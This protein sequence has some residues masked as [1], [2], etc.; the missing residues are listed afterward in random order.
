MRSVM[1]LL[2]SLFLIVIYFNLSGDYPPQSRV[3]RPTQSYSSTAANSAKPESSPSFS[4]TAQENQ[5]NRQP[6]SL[7][8]QSKNQSKDNSDSD[9]ES[10]STAPDS[11]AAHSSLAENT[12]NHYSSQPSVAPA[13]S[14]SS[15]TPEEKPVDESTSQPEI[16]ESS[17]S[18]VE[19]NDKQET[20]SYLQEYYLSALEDQ[21]ISLT[22]KTR[23]AHGLSELK[24]NADLKMS[25]RTR[26]REMFVGGYFEHKR[27]NGQEWY[28][29]LSEMGLPPMHA[30][31]NIAMGKYQGPVGQSGNLLS[32]EFWQ[33][34]W[35]KSESH[36]E[37]IIDPSLT[38]V[39][40]GFYYVVTDD[41]VS[42]YIT[43]MFA[44]M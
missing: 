40:V 4:Q 16:T 8:S 32:P 37:A 36:Y 5:E 17:S 28:T 42:A 22:N 7:S 26:S 11:S 15:S 29:V 13:T 20:A 44:E 38:D 30:R 24:F 9:S 25:A 27:P 21:I 35:E 10:S 34:Q 12:N 6:S 31:E 33:E 19:T 41:Y 14:E 18:Y 43:V 1:I 23:S 39:G 3:S 2:V